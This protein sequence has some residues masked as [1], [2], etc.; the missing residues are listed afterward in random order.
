MQ[1][2]EPAQ[3]IESYSVFCPHCGVEQA[4]SPENFCHYV[5]D[6]KEFDCDECE[7]LFTVVRDEVVTY[8]TTRI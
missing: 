5:S 2:K 8:K 1:T 7:K 6:D 4:E 3:S